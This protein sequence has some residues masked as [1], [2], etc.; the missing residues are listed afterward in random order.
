MR[1][2]AAG[3]GPVGRNRL[4]P[5]A[6]W[7]PVAVDEAHR[8]AGSEV[9][10]WAAARDDDQVP[11]ARRLYFTATPR[12]ASELLPDTERPERPWAQ[13]V[14]GTDRLRERRAAFAEAAGR[15]RLRTSPGY[16]CTR[17]WSSRTRAM[18]SRHP[19]PQ[20]A[21]LLATP[22]GPSEG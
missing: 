2:R 22:A 13:A 17:V 16:G 4:R 15:A 11:A 18:R 19:G 3:A 20:G 5:A 12:M 14:A 8:T 21:L 1:V 10:A 6:A 9:K 7:D